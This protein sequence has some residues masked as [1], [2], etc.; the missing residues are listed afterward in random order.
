MQ[1]K[2]NQLLAIALA[3]VIGIVSAASMVMLDEDDTDGD[4][5]AKQENNVPVASMYA[6]A[7]EIYPDDSATFGSRSKSTT[8]PRTDLPA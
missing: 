5:D 2:R 4:G 1:E 8:C 7:T 3:F 6:S